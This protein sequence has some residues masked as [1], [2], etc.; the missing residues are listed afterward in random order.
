MT[1]E[2]TET[3]VRHIPESGRFELRVDDSTAVLTYSLQGETMTFI[4]TEVPS[5]LEGRGI[6]SRLV[7]AG[8]EYAREKGF[9]VVTVC[10]FTAG[11]I[12]RHPEYQN[13]LAG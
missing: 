7:R 13:L 5:E 8:L 9:K 6:G 1:V 11:Y 12:E 3:G 10:W 4:S 2:N